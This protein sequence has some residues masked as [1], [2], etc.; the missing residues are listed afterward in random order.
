[1]RR[2]I[3]FMLI[4]GLVTSACGFTVKTGVS[5]VAD[6]ANAGTKIEDTAQ[7]IFTTASQAQAAALISRTALDTVAL[8]VN[9]VGHIG[10]DLN[11]TLGAY[12]QAKAAGSDLTAQRAAVQTVLS[13]I[14]QS[15]ADV[16]TAIP[17]GTLAD[18]DNAA[19]SILTIVAEVKGTVGL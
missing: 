7:L 18:I 8:A 10:I 1:M 9:K 2:L 15:M 5:P 12:N 13:T 11:A 19:T 3:P 14:E 17:R 16:G 6:V 4:L